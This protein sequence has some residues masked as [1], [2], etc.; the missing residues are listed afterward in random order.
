MVKIIYVNLF[1][2]LVITS[3]LNAQNTWLLGQNRIA[4]GTFEEDEVGK[5]PRK[6]EI[7]KGG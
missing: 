7:A 5:P 6:W 2:L 3:S 4:N 1:L